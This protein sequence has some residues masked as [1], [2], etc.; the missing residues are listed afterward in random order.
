MMWIVE[1]TVDSPLGTSAFESMWRSRFECRSGHSTHG[2]RI[3]RTEWCVLLFH[4]PEA[5][6]KWMLSAGLQG[7]VWCIDQILHA[8]A[9]VTQ[10]QEFLVSNHVQDLQESEGSVQERGE[11]SLLFWRN[12]N[13]VHLKQIHHRFL[14]QLNQ[15]LEDRGLKRRPPVSWFKYKTN[16]FVKKMIKRKK[17]SEKLLH[18]VWHEA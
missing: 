2:C 16:H 15:P 7:T 6:G 18:Y 14:V 17:L 12:A 13:L 8:T 11:Y 3:Y 5:T 9:V 4:S 10:I 1:S